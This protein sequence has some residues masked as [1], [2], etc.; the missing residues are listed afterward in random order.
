MCPPAD[1][2]ETNGANGHAN[3]ANGNAKGATNGANGS[4]C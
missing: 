3:S 1:E 4:M 2:I